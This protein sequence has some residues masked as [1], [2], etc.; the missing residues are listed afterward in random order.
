MAKRQLSTSRALL[1][2]AAILVLTL[3]VVSCFL[4]VNV[5]APN[6]R[7][8]VRRLWCRGTCRIIGISIERSGVIAEGHPVLFVANHVSYIDVIVL[9]AHVD[10][11][12]IAKSEISSWPFFGPLARLTGTMFVRRYWRC[13]N[14]QLNQIKERMTRG[15]DFILFG[16]GTSSNGLQVLPFK[17]SL[18]GV[19]E[20]WR[21]S[22]AATAQPV[23]LIYRSLMDG[24]PFDHHN[25]DLYAWF[26]ARPMVPHLSRVL[27]MKGAK[28]QVIFGAACYSW[29]KQ[30][31]K[32]FATRMRSDIVRELERDQDG[33]NDPVVLM[34]RRR[35]KFPKILRI[36]RKKKEAA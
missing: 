11:T 29:A 15:E 30:G 24:T 10:A 34:S 22:Q 3:L 18:F 32:E 31:R 19:V 12:F 23:T 5:V 4:I 35:R 17:T 6:A 13:A 33:L 28:V 16:E 25:A 20:P 26:G 9:G 2:A 7:S 14:L 1:R 21:M 8:K 27:R 36:P